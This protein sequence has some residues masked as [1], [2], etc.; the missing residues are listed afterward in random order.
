MLLAKYALTRTFGPWDFAEHLR[1]AQRHRRDPNLR[2]IRPAPGLDLSE[3]AIHEQ[4][5]SRDVAA[6]VVC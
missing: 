1:I 2:L 5:G 6:V 3:A 4:F